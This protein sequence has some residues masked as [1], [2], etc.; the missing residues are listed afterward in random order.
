MKDNLWRVLIIDDSPEDRQAMRLM[1]SESGLRFHITEADT[2]ALGLRISPAFGFIYPAA[3][4]S[5]AT[6]RAAQAAIAQAR[7]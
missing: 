5:L 2:G 7:R 6:A 1:L 4:A 3:E